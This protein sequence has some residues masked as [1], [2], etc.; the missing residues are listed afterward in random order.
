MGFVAALIA[1]L[2]SVA[3]AGAGEPTKASE[4]R[5]A[6][7]SFR[8]VVKQC[9]TSEGLTKADL[10]WHATNTYG[11]DC[12][13]VTSRGKDK[14]AYYI[15]TCTAA[16]APCLS[17]SRRASENHR[18]TGRL[19]SSGVLRHVTNSSWSTTPSASRSKSDKTA[20]PPDS[21]ELVKSCWRWHCHPDRTESG[22]F[23]L[24]SARL[25]TARRN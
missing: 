14:G 25:R 1:L 11:W 2:L 22:K 15:I 7:L 8:E 5:C 3:S 13:E 6:P 23:L 21:L 17:A 18:F 24:R 10:A 20:T 12:D 4:S 16:S 9:H 19:Q